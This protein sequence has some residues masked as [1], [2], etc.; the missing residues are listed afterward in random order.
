MTSVL[1]IAGGLLFIACLV[2][3]MHKLALAVAVLLLAAVLFPHAVVAMSQP[4]VNDTKLTVDFETGFTTGFV[5]SK[6]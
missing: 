6:G 4:H 5:R 2:E 1:I 3:R